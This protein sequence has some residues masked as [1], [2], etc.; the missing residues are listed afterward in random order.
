MELIQQI[1]QKSV[2]ERIYIIELILQSLKRD[3]N[4]TQQIPQ[5]PR[6]PFRVRKFNL[7]QEI[8]VDRDLIY[9]ERFM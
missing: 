2:E 3:M 7:G 9:Y 6:K 1:Q 4:F 5:K 8:H